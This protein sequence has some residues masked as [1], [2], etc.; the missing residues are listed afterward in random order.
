MTV[1]FPLHRRVIQAASVRDA[2]MGGEIS[3]GVR[4]PQGPILTLT[5]L[6]AAC[7]ATLPNTPSRSEVRKSA[8]VIDGREL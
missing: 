8:S 3:T 6:T 4:P 2:H 1:G 5:R 7:P